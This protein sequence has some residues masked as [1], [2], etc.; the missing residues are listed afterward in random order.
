MHRPT[1]MI[2]YGW[3]VKVIFN[4]SATRSPGES[5][6]NDWPNDSQIDMFFLW[7]E[8]GRFFRIA[9][10]CAEANGVFMRFGCIRNTR[11]SSGSWNFAKDEDKCLVGGI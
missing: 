6:T 2:S 1:S 3:S 9:I 8:D 4:S 11:T 7:E 10:S 5:T